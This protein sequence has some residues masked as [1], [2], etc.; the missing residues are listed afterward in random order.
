M[1]TESNLRPQME[2][3]VYRF[4]IPHVYITDPRATKIPQ[5]Q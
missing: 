1:G 4:A 2:D 3:S 5:G